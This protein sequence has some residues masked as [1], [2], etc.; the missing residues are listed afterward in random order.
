MHGPPECLGNIILLCAAHLYPEPKLHLGFANCMISDY[1]NIPDRALVEN[2]A[3]E[4]SLSFEKINNCI[5][6]EDVHGINLLRESVERSRENNVT[7]S[8]T[9]RLAGK[10][11]CIR[12]GG[13]W[14]DCEGGSEVDDLVRDVKELYDEAN[15]VV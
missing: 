6:D 2:C 5:S 3:L 13:V 4:H 8:C 14:K 15:S 10:V 11:R 9:V 1:P 7:K 12:D